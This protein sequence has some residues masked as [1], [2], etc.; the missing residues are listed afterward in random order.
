ML[1]MDD[2]NVP[3]HPSTVRRCF[4]TT[5]SSPRAYRCG[6]KFGLT[7]MGLPL[8]RS[9]TDCTNGDPINQPVDQAVIADG[10][11]PTFCEGLS[12]VG[13]DWCCPQ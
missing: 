3:V 6:L 4:K 10:S 13:P 9:G 12:M 7:R 11:D 8:G 2:E 1:R 5:L